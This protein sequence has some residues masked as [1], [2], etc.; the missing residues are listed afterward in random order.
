[1]DRMTRR[2]I[3]ALSALAAAVFLVAVDGTVLAV[4]V[5]SLAE[6]LQPSY[7]QILW[8]SDIYSFMLAGLL[9]TAGNL[10]DRVG[11]KRL[12]MFGVVG[13]GAMSV[14]AA[15][16]P[17]AELLIAARAVQGIAG[18][19][20]MPSTLALIRAVFTESRQRTLAVGI[21]SS[22]GSAGA[23]IGPFV[24]GVLLEHFSWGSVFLINVPVVIFILVVGLW[25]L[26]ESRGDAAQPIDLPSVALS[27]VGILALVFAIKELARGGWASPSPW[28][29]LAVGVPLLAAF[30][31]RQRR[32]PVPL[33]D[34]SLFR[35]PLFAGSVLAEFVMVF[36]A[37]GLLFFLALY[38]QFVAEFSPL[39]AGLALL[40]VSLVSLVVAPIAA[41]LSHRVGPRA[42]LLS[43]LWCTAAGL[44]FLAL[45]AGRD[46]PWFILPMMMVGYGFG[47]VVTVASD[48]VISSAPADRT[49][50]AGGISE[51]AFELGSAL[52]IAL[53]GSVLTLVYRGGLEVPVGVPA[54]LAAL[55]KDS[56]SNIPDLLVQLPAAVGDALLELG[57]RSFTVGLAVSSAAA[58]LLVVVAG[59]SA[60]RMLPRHVGPDAG[61]AGTDTDPAPGIAQGI[62]EVCE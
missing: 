52:G 8:I 10:G 23:A 58:A 55:A 21:W 3:A 28:L 12:L 24:A 57:Q 26:P 53:L 49:G 17:S 43:G 1:M 9:V 40:P 41:R 51:T 32:L 60:G 44:G 36:A 27:I 47:S 45:A 62:E 4:A 50:A 29:A 18:A 31:L 38:F 54:D 14:V 61:A 33:L 20:L 2:Q 11:R 22:T 56:L 5:P 16:A 35:I 42:V 7:T 25:A 19:A 59:I 39:Q 48:Q 34:T 13:F 46:Y 6:D 30:M 37:T 15:Y